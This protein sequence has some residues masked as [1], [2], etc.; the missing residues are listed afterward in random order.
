[1]NIVDLLPHLLLYLK[2]LPHTPPHPLLRRPNNA[3]L[4]F[5]GEDA[6]RTTPRPRASTV[7]RQLGLRPSR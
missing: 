6:I 3:L 5:R 1:M 7:Q 4:L 2:K